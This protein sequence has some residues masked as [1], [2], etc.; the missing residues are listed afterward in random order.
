MNSKSNQNKRK[1]EKRLNQVLQEERTTR[2]QQEMQ[3]FASENH[4]KTYRVRK[5]TVDENYHE[6]LRQPHPKKARK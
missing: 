3:E 2:V 4:H 6:T 5:G 1:F